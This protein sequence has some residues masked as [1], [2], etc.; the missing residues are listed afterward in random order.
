MNDQAMPGMTAE[1][2][3]RFLKETPSREEVNKYMNNLFMAINNSIGVF[4]GYTSHALAL[5]MSDYFAKLNL[6]VSPEDFLKRFTEH[7]IKIVQD[8]QEKMKQA[9][10]NLAE[11]AQSKTDVTPAKEVD[12]SVL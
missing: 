1:E 2:T 8:A 5:T 10:M 6:E 12:I 11:A 4:Q 9:E 3:E 7:N